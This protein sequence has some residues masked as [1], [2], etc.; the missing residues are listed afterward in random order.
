MASIKKNYDISSD[1]KGSAYCGLEI[2]WDY[3]NGTVDLYMPG[4]IKAALYNYRHPA[5]MRPEHAPH[6][7][8][9]P[10]YGCKT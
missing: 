3:I 6:Q 8:N 4:Y 7:W 2:G 5:R 10:I 9:P 1:W